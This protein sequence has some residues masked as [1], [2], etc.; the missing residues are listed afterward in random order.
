MNFINKGLSSI[1]NV[2]FYGV[3]FL[4]VIYLLFNI[5]PIILVVLVVT[6]AVIKAIKMVKTWGSRKGNSKVE[7]NIEVIKNVASEELP[8]REVIDV[9]YREVR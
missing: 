1:L 8:N 2:I 7:D 6:W 5:V 4:L 3:I 9:D